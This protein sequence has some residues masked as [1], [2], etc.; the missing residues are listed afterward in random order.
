[1]NGILDRVSRSSSA[2][3][4]THFRPTNQLEFF[5]LRLA[6]KLGESAAARHY[7]ELAEAHSEAT[8]LIAYRR[9]KSTHAVDLIRSFHVE[10]NRLANRSVHE[11]TDRRLAAIRVERRAVA[12]AILKGDH[13]EY[14]PL[15]RQLSSDHEKAMAS[16]PTFLDRIIARCPFETAALETVPE[17]NEIQRRALTDVA[18]Q[19]L[20]GQTVSIWQLPK[21]DVLSAFGHPPLRF[22]RDVREIA[23]TIWPGV[24]G[25]FG[26]PLIHDALALG[27]YCQIE[28]LF[29]L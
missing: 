17:T 12:V 22:R 10:L 24:N 11:T 5:A 25:S 14:P 8:L 13:L 26:A 28:Y 15:V 18:H 7:V 4:Y 2:F 6:Q 16:I 21:E 29:N 19:F 23:A 27:L 9:A 3:R 1:M 20:I